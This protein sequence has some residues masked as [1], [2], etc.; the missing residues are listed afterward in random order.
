MP[1]RNRPRSKPLSYLLMWL[2]SIRQNLRART[3]S[4]QE[5]RMRNQAGF[6][7][8]EMLVV[9][10]IMGLIMSLIG[11]RVLGYLADSKYKTARIQAETLAS[12]VEL[13]FIDNGRYPLEAEGLQALVAP[14]AG[15]NTWNGPYLRGTAVP[16][17]PWGKPYRYASERG[18]NYVVTFVGADGRETGEQRRLS[19]AAKP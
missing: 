7:L 5:S 3:V 10:T 6:T 14:P 4:R 1:H 15:L 9:L 16:L 13:F 2:R 18:R 8:V 11:P 17:D 19:A 12:A